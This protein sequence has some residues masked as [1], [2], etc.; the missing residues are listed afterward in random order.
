MAIGLAFTN[1]VDQREHALFDDSMRP[2][3]IWALLASGGTRRFG[4]LES[5]G[6]CRGG[7]AF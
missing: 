4:D 5:G 6:Q 2:S 7:D 3:N 1:L